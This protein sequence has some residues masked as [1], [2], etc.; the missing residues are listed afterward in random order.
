MDA[1]APDVRL[2]LRRLRREAP[3]GTLHY[4]VIESKKAGPLALGGE[5]A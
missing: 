4:L 1:F 3:A 2:A 5:P